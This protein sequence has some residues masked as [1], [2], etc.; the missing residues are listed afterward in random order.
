MKLRALVVALLLSG[1]LAH[2]DDVPRDK[3]AQAKHYFQLGVVAYDQA[4]YEV[5]LREFQ[6]AHALS[7]SPELYFNMAKCEENLEHF[8]GAALLLRQYLLERPEV[9]DRIDVERRIHTLEERGE[10]QRRGAAAT[11]ASKP[12]DSTPPRRVISWALLGTTGAFGVVALG[13]GVSTVTLH[14]RLADGCGATPAGCTSGQ[15]SELHTR[16]AA[17]DAFIALTAVAAVTTIVMFI[18]EPRLGKAKNGARVWDG[19]GFHF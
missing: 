17:S 13:L 8:S 5:A 7:H 18:V 4:Q 1:A 19:Q 2:A 9:P 6:Q 16:A 15:R 14:N 10:A 12:A 11:P 3:I